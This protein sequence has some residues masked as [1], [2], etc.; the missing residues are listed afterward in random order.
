MVT[1]FFSGSFAQTPREKVDEEMP[2]AESVA[3]AMKSRREIEEKKEEEKEKKTADIYA[4]NGSSNPFLLRVWRYR[5][6]H[7]FQSERLKFFLV[8]GAFTLFLKFTLIRFYEGVH[9]K[10][11]KAMGCTDN[12][13]MRIRYYR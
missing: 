13:H 10:C 3:A 8:G 1:D 12:S 7:F 6:K 4:W 9:I 11:L 5:D 2:A